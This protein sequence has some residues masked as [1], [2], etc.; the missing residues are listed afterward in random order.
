MNPKK[1]AIFIGTTFVLMAPYLAFG[2]YQLQR[3]PPGQVPR[4][5]LNTILAWF[6]ANF[7]ILWLVVT[8]LRKKR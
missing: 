3:F 4:W 6:V 8:R 1:G 2:V 5:V 7:L